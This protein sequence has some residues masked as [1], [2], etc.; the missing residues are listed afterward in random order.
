MSNSQVKFASLHN[1]L[2][3]YLHLYVWPFLAIWPAFFAFYLSE[4]RYTTYINGQEWTFVWAGSI[5]SLQT[6]TWLMTK[7]SVNLQSLFTSTTARDPRTA[8]LVK[9]VP[10]TNAGAAE[11]C[12]LI[13][14]SV[15]FAYQEEEKELQG[16]DE[17]CR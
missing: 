3:L 2:P 13:R 11:I 16:A 6:L 17:A 5:V 7:W 8:Q 14:D 12:P 10:V 1:P 9:I 4:E 15:G